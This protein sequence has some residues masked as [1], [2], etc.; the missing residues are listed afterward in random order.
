MRGPEC[1]AAAVVLGFGVLLSMGY[2]ATERMF[3]V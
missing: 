1:A 2:M 3:A